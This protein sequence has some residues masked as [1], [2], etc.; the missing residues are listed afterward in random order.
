MAEELPR[1]LDEKLTLIY[2]DP[3]DG[4]DEFL[5]FTNVHDQPNVFLID[6]G[7]PDSMPRLSLFE[8]GEQRKGD[9]AASY[10]INSFKDVCAG[11]ID[12]EL[13]A[14]M[15][16]LFGYCAQ[17]LMHV[18]NRTLRDLMELLKSPVE[19]MDGLGMDPED[20]V[21]RFFVE[22][23]I[24][25]QK[26]PAGF[27]ETVKY[28]RMRVHGFLNDP[29]LA[30]LF[31]NK[32]PTMSLAKVIEAGSVILVAT[33]K[34]HLGENGCRLIGKFVKTV[35]NRVVQERVRGKG[36]PIRL[37]EDE[38]QNSLNKG[39]CALLARMLDENRKFGL[40]INLATTRF[41]HIGTEMGD[42]VLTCT[43]T[44]VCG[45]MVGKGVS[46]IS[47]ELDRTYDEIKTLP[48]FR[49]YVKCGS[50]MEKAIIVK[51][52]ENPFKKFG[53]PDERNLF[54]LRANMA[55][56]FGAGYVQRRKRNRVEMPG[57]TVIEDVSM[58]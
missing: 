45:T 1:A 37:Y 52:P 43:A 48:N 3:V 54:K 46:H 33:R 41:G 32:E 14:P 47:P 28:V 7:D 11:L 16:T 56:R 38:F 27:R 21:Y 34:K 31:I 4:I 20:D 49:L 35:V 50:D 57:E 55:H 6:P 8:T 51:T 26:R 15:M 58:N 12:Q 23:V 17:V 18:E 44:K 42:A 24:G 25:T 9:L 40:S 36:V 13:T 29:I 19:F 53:K 30:K 22:D 2:I 5:K 39:N 10:M